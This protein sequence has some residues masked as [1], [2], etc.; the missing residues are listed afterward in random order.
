MRYTTLVLVSLQVLHF[1]RLAWHVMKRGSR[2]LG[3]MRHYLISTD[4]LRRFL[5]VE[6]GA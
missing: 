5:P 1:R 2:S 3:G 4:R 6:N